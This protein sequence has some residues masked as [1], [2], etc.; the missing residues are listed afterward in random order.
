[1]EGILVLGHGGA[2]LGTEPIESVEAKKAL[3]GKH[4]VGMGELPQILREQL[5]ESGVLER[6]CERLPMNVWVPGNT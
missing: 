1:M 4:V 2:D 3:L 5:T 6:I